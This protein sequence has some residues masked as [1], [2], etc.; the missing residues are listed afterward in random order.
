MTRSLALVSLMALVACLAGCRLEPAPEPDPQGGATDVAPAPASPE[1][2]GSSGEAPAVVPPAQ[3]A[4]APEIQ[5]TYW[6]NTEPLSLAALRGKIVVL[7]FWATWCPPCRTTIPHLNT[8][9]EQYKDKGVAFVSLTNEP[10]EKV[11]GFAKEMNM[12]YPI[13]G[14][15][16]TG[17]DY[18]VRGIPHAFIIDP[19]GQVAWQGHPMAGLDK[20][21]DA[22]LKATPPK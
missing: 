4:G 20:A 9:F 3:A 5:A 11:E 21:I 2:K 8:M 22:Q 17:R 7:E 18:K 16:Q 10:R 1:P 13:G 14:G 6:M 15:S 12:A 19:S